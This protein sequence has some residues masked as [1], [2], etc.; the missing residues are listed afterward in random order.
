MKSGKRTIEVIAR[1]V[2]T[3]GS[4]VLL[5]QNLKHGYFFLPGG[6]VEFGETA[7]QALAREILEET[8]LTAKVGPAMLV[9]EQ[10]FT[11][12]DGKAHHE[13]SVVFH[14]ERL[15]DADGS[16]TAEVSSREAKIGFEWVELAALPE[17]DVRPDEH[18]AMLVA[19]G[20]VEGDGV[21]WVSN[22]RVDPSRL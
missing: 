3:D 7:A 11:S 4:R 13:V 12:D 19:G 1:G 17:A 6:H 20:R 5:C 2:A 14:V 8:G 16:P 15:A 21:A 18:K 9:G 10:T 22:P